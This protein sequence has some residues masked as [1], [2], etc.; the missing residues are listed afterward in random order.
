M[1]CL[2][3]TANDVD[4]LADQLAKGIWERRR[5]SGAVET[6]PW[7]DAPEYWRRTF[8]EHAT[9]M[10]EVARGEQGHGH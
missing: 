3:C 7:E 2:I 8:R 4:A 1:P 9:V 5:G 6:V 10:I